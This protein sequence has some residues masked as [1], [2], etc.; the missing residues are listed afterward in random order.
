MFVLRPASKLDFQRPVIQHATNEH[1]RGS[2][3]VHSSFGLPRT[4]NEP[5]WLCN[6]IDGSDACVCHAGC[7]ATAAPA[8]GA[9]QFNVRPPMK[10]R[11]IGFLASIPIGITGGF[12]CALVIAGECVLWRNLV[13]DRSS[14]YDRSLF[15]PYIVAVGVIP[16]AF[17]GGVTLPLAYAISLRRIPIARTGRAIAYLFVGVLLPSTLFSVL[18]E[19]GA[20]FAACICFFFTCI[21]ITVRFAVPNQ[22]PDPT[23]ASGTPLA[24]PESRHP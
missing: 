20:F 9:D 16:G 8:I 2:A 15:W 13:F 5:H 22:S 10:P 19:L 23:L 3:R 11:I 4:R 14:A 12:I 7:G 6:T 1:Q 17:L 18:Q 21:W 24:E